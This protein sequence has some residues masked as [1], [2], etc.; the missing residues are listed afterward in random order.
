[1]IVEQPL[2]T[3][4]GGSEILGEESFSLANTASTYTY[5]VVRWL[6]T[7]FDTADYE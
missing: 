4:G 6:K 5:R 3:L 1:M 2:T 7:V